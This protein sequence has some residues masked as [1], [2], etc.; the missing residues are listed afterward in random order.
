[1]EIYNNFYLINGKINGD[2]LIDHNFQHIWKIYLYN[3]VAGKLY[4]FMA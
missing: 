3:H 1:M 2:Q 4:F